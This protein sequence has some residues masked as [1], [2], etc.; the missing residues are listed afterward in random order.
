M[1]KA[2]GIPKL[3]Q[4]AIHGSVTPNWAEG[5]QT[6]CSNPSTHTSTPVSVGITEED[7]GWVY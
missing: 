3:T 7:Q 6:P 4:L 5:L 2:Q 1:K